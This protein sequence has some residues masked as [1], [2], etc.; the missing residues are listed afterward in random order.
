MEEFMRQ[1]TECAVCFKIFNEPRILPCLHTFCLGCID[2]IRKNSV[3]TCPYCTVTSDY[4]SMKV[5]FNAKE[6]VDVRLKQ[7][8]TAKT[9]EPVKRTRKQHLENYCR[10][11]EMV[12]E[13]FKTN[14]KEIDESTEDMQETKT[15]I[16]HISNQ[17]REKCVAHI[18][19]QFDQLDSEVI[20]HC[21][22]RSAA[23][24][25]ATVEIDEK[26]KL[27]ENELAASHELVTMETHTEV[28][29]EYVRDLSQ[30]LHKLSEKPKHPL[31]TWNLQLIPNSDWEDMKPAD[32]HL[33][34][35]VYEH[36]P[37]IHF[38]CFTM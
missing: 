19:N 8:A 34:T 16:L 1:K 7:E 38:S 35:Q 17:L 26:L 24:E 22:D 3:I 20:Q 27:V 14:K 28:T 10:D 18:H 37:L 2:R 5:D 33:S 36:G 12:I 29:V 9:N 25:T 21:R 31:Q 4:A 32:V 23:C 6:M 15:S 30:K 11:L 13:N